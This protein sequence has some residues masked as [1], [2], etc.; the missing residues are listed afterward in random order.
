MPLRITTRSTGQCHQEVEGR[1]HVEVKEVVEALVTMVSLVITVTM[2]TMVAMVTMVG[3]PNI[4]AMITHQLQALLPTIVTKI[5]NN[6]INQGN[7]NGGGY[8]NGNGENNKGGHEHGN[9]RNVKN[10]YNGNGCSY[11]EFW[12]A[13]GREATMGIT[14]DDF[15]ELLREEYCLNNEMQKLENNF[16]NHTMVGF[17]HAAYT[18]RFHGLAKLVPH[19]VTPRVQEDQ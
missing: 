14:W 12:H 3:I 6:A 4:V 16:W 9:L 19:L 10:N 5:S 15:K 11:K 17:G 1:V 13:R 8:D 18:D 2:V 7:G